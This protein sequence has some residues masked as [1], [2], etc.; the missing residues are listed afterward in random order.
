LDNDNDNS[1]MNSVSNNK[2]RTAA[3]CLAGKK[4]KTN[5]DA[6]SK[7]STFIVSSFPDIIWESIASYSSPP[8]VYNLALTSRYFHYTS[9]E[10]SSSSSTTGP[11]LPSSLPLLATRLLRKSLLSSFACVLDNAGTGIDINAA[12]Q[13]SELSKGSVLISGSAM[14]QT[15]LGEIWEGGDVDIYCLNEFAPQVRSVSYELRICILYEKNIFQ[16]EKERKI[17]ECKHGN[18]M[19]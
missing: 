13:L 5:A 3:A 18:E 10:S 14:V 11:L 8:D 17:S 9:D 7:G 12:L 1:I 2:S 6:L 16:I 15:C 19:E 4:R